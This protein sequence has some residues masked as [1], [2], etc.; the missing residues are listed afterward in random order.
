MNYYLQKYTTHQFTYFIYCLFQHKSKN[1]KM[2]KIQQVHQKI[3]AKQFSI[4]LYIL[5]SIGDSFEFKATRET[6]LILVTYQRDSCENVNEFIL[7][8]PHVMPHPIDFFPNIQNSVF[9]TEFCITLT[10][11]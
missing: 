11:T 4:I 10:C 6:R 9:G 1:P 2:M 7:M 8:S 5:F 3:H